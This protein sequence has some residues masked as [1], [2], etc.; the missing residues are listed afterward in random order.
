MPAALAGHHTARGQEFA[1][2]AAKIVERAAL[3]GLKNESVLEIV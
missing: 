2:L 3:A 1:A